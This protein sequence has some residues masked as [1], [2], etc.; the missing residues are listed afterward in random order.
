VTRPALARRL[1]DRMQFRLSRGLV[2]LPPGWQVRLSGQPPVRRD[3]LTLDP[4]LQLL[5]ALRERVGLPP[6]ETL[7][8]PQARARVRREA[9]AATGRPIPVRSV[10][11]LTVDGPAGPLPARHYVPD[12]PGGP[13][14]LLL[15]LH[16]GGFVICDLDTHD[17]ACRLLCRQAG[18][19]V[20]S[21]DYRLAPEYPFPAAVDDAHA[22][23]RWAF[24]N[25]AR[26]GADP[27]RVAIGGDSAGGNL[28]A[29]AAQSA[30]RDG[31][32]SP[33]LQLLIYPAVDRTR[34]YPSLDL[35]A[36][37]FF[38]TRDEI[39]WF[40]RTYSAGADHADPRLSPL[41]GTG[42]SGL[43]PAL[44]VT[45]GFDP[46]RDE[47]EA[48]AAALEA[49]GTPVKLRREPAMIHGFINMI[50]LSSSARTTFVDIARE[51]RA[52]L[53]TPR[54]GPEP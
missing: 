15:F 7:P 20:L 3:G 48:Y 16:G 53:G 46:L 12:E 40:D 21:V 24:A 34:P 33:A 5:L 47:G 19:H 1:I 29:V 6:L 39:D 27:R 30:G 4:Q 10:S 26:L 11:D 8:P 14:P 36:E 50:D 28:A 23:L 17:Q 13:H 22:A 18:V 44:V 45:A 35:F 49:A 42:L 37:G 41:L 31:D 2:A 9:G 54:R 25:A 51:V 38:L 52:M 43:A 32:L